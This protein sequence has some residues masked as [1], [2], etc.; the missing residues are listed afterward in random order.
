MIKVASKP[1]RS[2]RALFYRASE[3]AD[4][5]NSLDL[6]VVF[7]KPGFS[8]KCINQI[9]KSEPL[10]RLL[11]VSASLLKVS[12]TRGL[13]PKHILSILFKSVQM[14]WRRS[15]TCNNNIDFIVIM[16]CV[17]VCVLLLI[18]PCVSVVTNLYYLCRG[19]LA[20]TPVLLSLSPSAKC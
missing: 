8:V 12:G 17:C 13:S 5:R 20:G 6:M 18:S 16:L 14:E 4:G 3:E 1:Q 2:A 15:H 10:L 11:K 9:S 19:I 7:C